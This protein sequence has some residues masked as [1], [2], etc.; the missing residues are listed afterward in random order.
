MYRAVVGEKDYRKAA[1]AVKNAGYAT[2]PKYAEKLIGVI[3]TNNLTKYDVNTKGVDLDLRIAIDAGHGN[4]TPGKRAPDDSMREFHFN[5]VVAK[6]VVEELRTYQGVL[7]EIT[8][9]P[10]GIRDIPLKERTDKANRWGADAFV[11]IHANA[12][13]SAWSNANGIETYVYTSKPAGAVA[14]ATKV[15]AALIASTGLRDRG[16]KVANFH[17][18]RETKMDA[19]LVECGFMDN[20][21]ELA[22]LKSDSYRRKCAQAIVSGLAKQFG[23]K[24]KSGVVAPTV[25]KEESSVDKN[26]PSAWAKKDWDEAV[27]NGYFDGTRPQ[28]NI[29]REEMAVVVNRLRNNLLP[30]I[31]KK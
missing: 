13:G 16:V 18:L 14:L 3:E 29:T 1:W 10:S 31:Y 4:N 24:K 19:I 30:L 22:L 6:Y 9:D 12:V 28:D 21:A 17:V 27:A 25:P 2:D 7:V 26:K 23:L 8:H 20:P 11:S 5:S 15:Q